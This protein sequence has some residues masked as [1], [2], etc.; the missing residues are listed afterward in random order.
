MPF[1]YHNKDKNGKSL[2][3]LS[4]LELIFGTSCRSAVQKRMYI[5]R[6]NETE[7]NWVHTVCKE[8]KVKVNVLIAAFFFFRLSQFCFVF[9]I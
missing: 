2:S 3:S 7:I 6:C 8:I 4:L 9:L 5:K 1:K